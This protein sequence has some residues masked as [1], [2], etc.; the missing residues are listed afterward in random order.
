MKFLKIKSVILPTAAVLTVFAAAFTHVSAAQ[1]SCIAFEAPLAGSIFKTPSCTV[2]L[3][4]TCP[5]VTRVD[6]QARYFPAGSDSATIITLGAI[7]RP[8]YKL[9]WNTSNLPNQLFTG[10]GILAEA[11]IQGAMPQVTRQEGIFL[12]HNPVA[13]KA[14]PIPYAQSVANVNREAFAQ[15]FNMCSQNPPQRSGTSVIAWNERELLVHV[16]VDDRSFYSTQPGRNI[17]EAGIEVLIDPLRGRSPH[18]A[19]DSILFVVV[20]LQGQPFR[21]GFRADVTDGAFRLVPLQS[22][23]VGYTHNVGIG[24]FRGY[25]VSLSIPRE[26]F[27]GRTLPDTVAVNVVLRVLDD[28]GLQRIPLVGGSEHEMYSPFVWHDYY[29]L[30]K[31]LLMNAALQWVLFPAIGFLLALAVYM[32]ISK[33]R[34]PQLLSSF[35]RSEEE[36]AIFE[37]VNNIIEQELVKKDLKIEQVAR[38]CRLDPQALNSLLKRCTG[39]TFANYLLFCRT[40][41]AKERLR[42]SRSSEKSIADLCGFASAMEMEKCFMKFHR[43]T[44]YKFRTQQQ[45]A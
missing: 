1:A 23:R 28:S 32:I 19:A 26:V 29:R 31:P 5:N 38:R 22:V 34:K 27:G 21:A 37:Q 17:A 2:S 6:L 44:P 14:I 33:L 30:P 18:P 39:F 10:A 25:N 4:V 35:E 42:S 12:V 43:T 13:R 45:V 36:K 11:T 7:T 3:N 40:E 15:S 9:I 16:A 8:P 24:E 20:P 41:V